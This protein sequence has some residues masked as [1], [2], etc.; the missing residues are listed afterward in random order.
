MWELISINEW[1][2]SVFLAISCWFAAGAIHRL[3]HLSYLFSRQGMTIGLYAF[4][5][6]LIEDLTPL[7]VALTWGETRE[8]S[9][10]LFG[11]FLLLGLGFI[12]PIGLD[13][14]IQWLKRKRS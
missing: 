7:N 5:A 4:S 10:S 2:F 9:L 1:I 12:L 6:L 14:S 13:R 3:L 11:F 8:Q